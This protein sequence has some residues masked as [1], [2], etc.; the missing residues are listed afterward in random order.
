MSDGPAAELT[1][2]AIIASIESGEYSREVIATIA[3]GFL[4]LPQEELIAVLT[5]VGTIDDPELSGL[6][7]TS[8]KEIP[9][10]SLFDFASNEAI[11]PRHLLRLTQVIEDNLTLE[12]LIRNRA[13]TDAAVAEL[14]LRANPAVQEVIIIN[15]ARVL[16]APEILDALE[17]NPSLSPEV[18]RRLLETREEFFEKRERMQRAIDE[19]AQADAEAAEEELGEIS[20]DPIADLLEA[21]AA[22]DAAAEVPAPVPVTEAEKNDPKKF[23][24]WGR[25]QFM[26]VSEKVQLAFKGDKMA[27][28]LLVRERNKLICSAVIRNPRMSEQEVENIA[29]MRNVDDV[30]LRLISNRRDWM[31][32]YP[33]VIALARNP[34]TPAGVVVPL[35]NRLTLRDLKMLK[36]DKGVSQ[37]VREMS[38]KFY[39]ARAN[40]T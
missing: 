15:Q 19:A 7:R 29:G 9:P 17:A 4:P 22:L 30:V 31:G 5:F 2:D 12:A 8:I 27:R 34:K 26:S 1:A 10:R 39:Q 20:L 18:R 6:A 37:V 13:V 3:R 33:I 23:A 38:K 24:L 40:K 14:A 36:D 28:T 35:V 16:R 32:K 21:A 25:L 11:A